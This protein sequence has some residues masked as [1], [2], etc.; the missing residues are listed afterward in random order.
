MICSLPC[1]IILFV[2]NFLTSLVGLG[3]GVVGGL[4]IW[5]T[6][7]LQYILD[8]LMQ[9]FIQS[10]SPVIDAAAF[11][12]IVNRLI[13]ATSPIGLALFVLGCVI[14]LI[15]LIGYSGACCDSKILYYV[16]QI[17]LALLAAL[18][19]ALVVTYYFKKDAVA[20]FAL[21]IFADSVNKYKSMATNDVH[22]LIVGFISPALNCCG[23]HNASDFVNMLHWDEFQS[24]NFTNLE[25]PL[26]CCKMD[27]TYKIIDMTCPRHFTTD[28]SNVDRGCSEP[29]RENFFQ[30]MDYVV[31]ALIVGLG[32]LLL[33]IGLTTFTVCF[34]FK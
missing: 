10:L 20:G 3:L 28:N 2:V 5:G 29:L 8:Q 30:F 1:R 7:V 18:V 17:L 22:S 15:S 11:S 23:V 19:V 25:Y 27:A 12:E 26:I 34:N 16:Y 33:L 21:D 14:F 32:L 31:I 6:P 13:T 4:M 9:K 24:I